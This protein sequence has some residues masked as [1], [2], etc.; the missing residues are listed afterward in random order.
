MVDSFFIVGEKPE[1]SNLLKLNKVGLSS[2]DCLQS[3]HC[4]NDPIVK[5]TDEHMMLYMSW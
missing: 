4:I 5:L 3:N 1:L 2:N